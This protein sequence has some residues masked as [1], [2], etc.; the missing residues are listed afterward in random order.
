[1]QITS[2]AQLLA[3]TKQIH[4][5]SISWAM[6]CLVS[7]LPLFLP[8][9][10]QIT[11][12]RSLTLIENLFLVSLLPFC[13][14]LLNQIHLFCV[15]LC[16]N[17][18]FWTHTLNYTD[19]FLFSTKWWASWEQ[20][21]F[22]SSLETSLLFS[23]WDKLG[24]SQMSYKWMKKRMNEWIKIIMA[25]LQ[26]ICEKTKTSHTPFLTQPGEEESGKDA[27]RLWQLNSDLKGIRQ[28]RDRRFPDKRNRI[29]R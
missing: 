17:L 26:R 1:M 21:L 20:T 12:W 16:A 2:G 19:Q 14:P 27:W 24:A 28:E 13:S 10:L 18:N 29:Q 4:N 15:S 8:L 5:S 22:I 25:K 9:Y 23:T 6:K 3:I 11:P 7:H